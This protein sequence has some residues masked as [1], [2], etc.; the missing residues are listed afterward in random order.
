MG[1]SSAGRFLRASLSLSPISLSF[2][3]SLSLLP[4]RTCNF[5]GFLSFSSPSPPSPCALLFRLSLPSRITLGV[6]SSLLVLLLRSFLS[7]PPFFFRS[8]DP[9][10]A[11]Y[12]SAHLPQTQDSTAFFAFKVIPFIRH[13]RT[14]ELCSRLVQLIS[15]IYDYLH[16]SLG[17]R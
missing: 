11:S 5:E 12:L 3:L 10:R 1:Q 4:R 2:F 8:R 9:C 13:Y 15:A 6:C 16:I 17:F 7:F 14:L